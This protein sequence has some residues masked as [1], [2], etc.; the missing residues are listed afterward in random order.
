MQA[1]ST[2]QAPPALGPYSQAALAN[3]LLFVSGQLGIDPATGDMP[4]DFTDQARLVFANLRAILTAAGLGF[5]SVVKASVFLTDMGHFSALNEIYASHFSA[6]YPAREA[7]QVARLPR[8]G[9]IEISL[10]AVKN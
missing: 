4:P 10:I 6:P 5:S 8:D 2:T 7:V 1:I 9:Q 3:G